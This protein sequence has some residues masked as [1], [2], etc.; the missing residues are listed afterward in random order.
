MHASRS[1]KAAAL[2]AVF[3][4]GGLVMPGLHALHHANQDVACDS[5][6]PLHMAT[7][8]VHASEDCGLCDA[9][10]HVVEPASVSWQVVHRPVGEYRIDLG[11]GMRSIAAAPLHIRGPPV[12]FALA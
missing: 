5:S 1:I 8:S 6:M 12:L 9:V 3:V 10:L 11:R 4:L 2:L 7:S